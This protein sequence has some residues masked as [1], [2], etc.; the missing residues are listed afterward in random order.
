[1]IDH[2]KRIDPRTESHNLISYV[3]L[4]ENGNPF[5]GM[6]NLNGNHNDISSIKENVI[7]LW[8]LLYIKVVTRQRRKRHL[9]PSLNL[10]RMIRL[11][12][13]LMGS[14]LLL[15]ALTSRYW[16]PYLNIGV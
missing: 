16:W 15:F 11:G 3:F 7:Q 10:S 12:A 2:E 1:M 5:S 8:P 13:I 4:D 9:I 6:N 14:A